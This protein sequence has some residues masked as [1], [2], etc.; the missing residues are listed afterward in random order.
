MYNKGRAWHVSGSCLYFQGQPFP[1]A[2]IIN[3]HV[4]PSTILLAA[5]YM[6]C[7][8]FTVHLPPAA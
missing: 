6:S 5:W 8:A 2:L 7:P 1:M 3:I 4:L